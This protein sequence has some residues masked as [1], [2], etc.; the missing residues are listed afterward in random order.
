MNQRIV[1]AAL[2]LSLSRHVVVS[3]FLKS[4]EKE[5]FQFVFLILVSLCSMFFMKEWSVL[6]AGFNDNRS[7]YTPHL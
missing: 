5:V 7:C 1:R 2:H 4:L 3:P 6:R